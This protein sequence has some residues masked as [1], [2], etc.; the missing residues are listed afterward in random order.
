ME[1]RVRQLEGKIAE[2]NTAIAVMNV[3]WEGID[4]RLA[5]LEQISRWIAMLIIGGILGAVAGTVSDRHAEA[6]ERPPTA[7]ASGNSTAAGDRLCQSALRRMKV[8]ELLARTRT[9]F[10]R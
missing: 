10:S 2:I 3:K 6:S 7:P 1:D 4:K 5:G 8:V 9:R